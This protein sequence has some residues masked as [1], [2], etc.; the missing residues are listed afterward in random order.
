MIAYLYAIAILLVL[1]LLIAIISGTLN[2][3]SLGNT[4]K[5]I[6]PGFITT[7]ILGALALMSYED[8]KFLIQN[9]ISRNTFFNNQVTSYGSVIL[10]G[11]VFDEVYFLLVHAFLGGNT[12]YQVAYG[13]FIHNVFLSEAMGFLY[14]ILWL[15]AVV[16]SCMAVGSFLSLFSKKVQRLIIIGGFVAG[17]VFLSIISSAASTF[18]LTWIADLAKFILGYQHGEPTTPIF[19]MLSYLLWGFVMLLISRVFYNRKQIKRI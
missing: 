12:F 2:T 14:H 11:A 8:Y 16:A 15:A 18:R 19:L 5:G 6:E 3:F 4:I 13:N 9:G 10:I 1:P 7:F 17:V